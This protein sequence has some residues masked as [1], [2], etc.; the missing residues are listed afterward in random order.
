MR[1]NGRLDVAFGSACCDSVKLSAVAQVQ[2]NLEKVGPDG[3]LTLES[4][5]ARCTKAKPREARC[6]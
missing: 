5:D 1:Y 6:L 3:N 4:F 2:V